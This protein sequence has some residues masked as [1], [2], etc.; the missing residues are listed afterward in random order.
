MDHITTQAFA[1]ATIAAKTDQEDFASLT[2]Q[3]QKGETKYFLS[4]LN[5]G[6]LILV[7]L[8]HSFIGCAQS[9][10]ISVFNSLFSYYCRPFLSTLMHKGILHV[11]LLSVIGDIGI[12]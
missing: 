4:D 1:R 3:L 5:V 11:E 2:G 7:K 12:L 8:D 10:F 9:P 6:Y